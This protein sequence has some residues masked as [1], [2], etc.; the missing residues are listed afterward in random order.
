VTS[1]R[2]HLQRT[3]RVSL[4]PARR[5]DG[6]DSVQETSAI[7]TRLREAASLPDTLAVAFDAFEA[8][9][10][11]ARDCE[12][13]LPGLLAT[14]MT[15]ADAAVDGREAITTAP[16]LPP[17]AHT[18]IAVSVPAPSAPVED[19]AAALAA[20]GAV[21]AERLRH[22]ATI[23]MTSADQTACQNAALAAGRIWQLMTGAEDGTC[24]R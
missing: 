8:I 16:A 11:L 17:P 14:F 22:A 19:V 15:T 20:L 18:G 21:L 3:T 24:P 10:Q 9:R 1:G 12:D 2:P 6:E 5:R 13:R 4:T 7:M 23:A